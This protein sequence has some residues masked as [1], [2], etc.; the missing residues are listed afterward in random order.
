MEN[1]S[2]KKESL[3]RFGDRLRRFR[4]ENDL[5]QAELSDLIDVHVVQV[6][7]YEKGRSEPTL[8]VIRK[9][10]VALGKT[11]D[12][13]VFDEI[14]KVNLDAKFQR[15]YQDFIELSDLEKYAILSVMDGFRLKRKIE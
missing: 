15:Y 7:N 2:A 1:I 14:E 13:L 12:E 3:T 8:S 4:K 11:A 6:K 9:M 5:T 10:A